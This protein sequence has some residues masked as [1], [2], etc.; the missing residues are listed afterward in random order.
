MWSEEYSE[1]NP[2]DAAKL[3]VETGDMVKVTSRRGSITA[4]IKVTD[5]VPPGMIWMSF[6]Y[7]ASPTNAIT[8]EG[9]DPITKTGEYKVCAVRV[10]KA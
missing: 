4:R 7:A 1:F 3:G 2:V 5:R 6:H 9:L 10:E 8:S